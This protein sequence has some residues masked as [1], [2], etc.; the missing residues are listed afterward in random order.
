MS[1]KTREYDVGVW[2]NALFKIYLENYFAPLIWKNSNII[3]A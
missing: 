2:F 3:I 1:H